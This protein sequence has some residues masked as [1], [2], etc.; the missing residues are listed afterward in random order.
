MRAPGH[1]QG[2]FLTEILMDEL[3]DRVKMDPVAFRV[4]NLPPAAPNA[5]WAEYFARGAKAFG[6]DKRHATG[7]PTPGPDQ[8]RH[9]RARRIA[10]A[11]AAAARRR[12]CDITSDGSVVMKCGTQDIGTGT[13]TLVAM[14]AAET[15]GL[16]VS[17]V[18]A[19]DR[20]HDA[21]R[22]AADPAAARRRRRSMPAIRVAAVK[23]L[24]ALF[25]KVAPTLGVDRRQSRRGGRPHLTS[26][27]TPSKG[28]SWKDACKLIGTEPISVD[29]QWED[30]LSATGTSGV[31]FAEVDG[32]H[33][34]RHRPGDS[35]SSRFRTAA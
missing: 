17:A 23:A 7:D 15:L 14:V 22:S 35:A 11:A 10:G 2:C 31:Q 32:R 27:A 19:G 26:K 13:R 29:G 21:I 4:K 5:M 6:W 1:P 18:Q 8:D 9:G 12:T 33:R 24:D 25:A 28:V 20:R 16:P 3:A 30:G 34:N